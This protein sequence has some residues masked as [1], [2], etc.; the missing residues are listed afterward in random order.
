MKFSSDRL[1]KFNYRLKRVRGGSGVNDVRSNHEL[2]ALGDNQALRTIRSIRYER[3]PEIERYNPDVLK[4]LYAA[5][6]ELKK[7]VLTESVKKKISVV[8][9]RIDTMLFMPEY[10]SVVINDI[11]H[12][13]KIIKDGLF[14]NG[15]KY[16]RLMCSAGQARVN[17]VILIREDYEEEVKNR[18]RCGAKKVKIT[19][20]NT[21]HILHSLPLPLI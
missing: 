2:I 1:E 8:N 16:V 14:I 11:G 5:K 21:M 10:I 15:F 7:Q 18:L 19:K 12:Y 3:H 20:I 17:T 6:K 4:E 13:Y 9:D